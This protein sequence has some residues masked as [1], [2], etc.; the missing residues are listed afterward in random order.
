MG[1][2]YADDKRLIRRRMEARRRELTSAEV[3]SLS[4]AACERVLRL[5]AFAAALHVVAYAAIENELDPAVIT[6]V[7]RAGGKAVY[8]PDVEGTVPGF[9]RDSGRPAALES[10]DAVLFLV[11]GVAFDLHGA[12]LG[13]GRGWYDRALARYPA[14]T[15]LG[16]AYEFQV[17][18]DLPEA[19]WDVRMHA[20]VT[21]ARLIGEAPGTARAQKED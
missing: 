4:A 20:L 10:A 11:P 12:R 3:A 2:A 15:R 18:P 9:V 19:P 21:E 17:V 16:L 5:P 6:D 13:R 8:Y 7:S 1:E 14:A